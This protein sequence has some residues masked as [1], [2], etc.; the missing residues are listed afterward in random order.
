[1]RFV[2]VGVMGLLLTVSAFATMDLPADKNA[3]RGRKILEE[4]N[5]VAS[6][7]LGQAGVYKYKIAG[8]CKFVGQLIPLSEEAEAL[9]AKLQVRRVVYQHLAE[10]LMKAREILFVS[11][12]DICTAMKTYGQP[13]GFDKAT[14]DKDADTVEQNLRDLVNLT[15]LKN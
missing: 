15:T 3:D 9:S 14:E 12:V 7:G 10:S 4:M 8:L 13:Q 2:V 1:M 11:E 5:G 6:N